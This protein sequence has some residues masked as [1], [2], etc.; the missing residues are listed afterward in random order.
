M[1]KKEEALELRRIVRSLRRPRACRQCQARA[2]KQ[3]AAENSFSRFALCN[4]G[5]CDDCDLAVARSVLRHARRRASESKRT[6]YWTFWGDSRLCT[7]HKSFAA[8][9]REARR[10]ER[11]GGASHEIYRVEQCAHPV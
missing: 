9:L 7:K 10:C 2:D 3:G 1:D 8:A 5:C 6:E 11:A 4:F